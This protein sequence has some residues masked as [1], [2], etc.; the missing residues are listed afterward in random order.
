MELLAE[1]L[2]WVILLFYL[3]GAGMAYPLAYHFVKKYL[4]QVDDN[5]DRIFIGVFVATFSW[6]STLIMLS[7]LLAQSFI[8]QLDPSEMDTDKAKRDD[9]LVDNQEEVAD[10]EIFELETLLHAPVEQ[11]KQG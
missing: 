10:D 6:L 1:P 11:T 9:S 8:Y 4:T 3:C 7:A 2:F 5:G